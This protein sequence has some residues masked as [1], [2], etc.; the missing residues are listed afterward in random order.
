MISDETIKYL[1][2]LVKNLHHSER[3]KSGLLE[4]DRKELLEKIERLNAK[5]NE[6]DQDIICLEDIAEHFGI[7][8]EQDAR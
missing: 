3:W 4:K 7:D 6:Y 8:L 2:I 1:T 5:I